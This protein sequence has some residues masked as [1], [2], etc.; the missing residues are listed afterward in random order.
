MAIININCRKT[1][2]CLHHRLRKISLQ[3]LKRR[4][5]AQ[6][7]VRLHRIIEI[8]KSA[9]LLL[10]MFRAVETLLF[11]PHF[12]QGT[13]NPLCLTVGLRTG[14]PGKLLTNPVL[15]TGHTESMA[16]RAF[17]F[18]TVVGV[19]ALNQVGQGSIRCSVRN[20][21]ALSAVLS[22]RMAAYSSLEKSS[23]ATNR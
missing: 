13:D 12:H 6:T 7:T 11:M 18:R 15:I 2:R 9:Q 8:N 10:P 21:A 22:G 14:N 1:L 3:D 17:V 20:L 4:I 23:M 19:N 5:A 16:G